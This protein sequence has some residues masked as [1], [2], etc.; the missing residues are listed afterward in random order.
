MTSGCSAFKRSVSSTGISPMD[1]PCIA[2][3]RIISFILRP[4]SEI[5]RKAAVFGEFIFCSLRRSFSFFRL[6]RKLFSS[7]AAFS[8][9]SFSSLSVSSVPN[10]DSRSAS[11]LLK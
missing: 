2:Y 11:I 5:E 9:S 6:S 4:S 3:I 8:E 1:M 10:S 7:S